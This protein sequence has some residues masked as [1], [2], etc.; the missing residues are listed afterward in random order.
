MGLTSRGRSPSLSCMAHI[1]DR[2]DFTAAIFVV[3]AEK[4][5]LVHHRQ[6]DRWLPLGGHIEPQEHH[7]IRWCSAADLDTLQPPM[8][9]A[10]KWYCLRALEELGDRA[11]A[12]HAS[13]SGAAA[14]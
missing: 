13:R 12:T 1:H 5:L 2:I 4:V 6:L 11:S 7:D 8:E 10:V 3:H 9:H 14:I